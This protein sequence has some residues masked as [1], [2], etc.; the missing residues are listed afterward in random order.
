MR[1][2]Q[3]STGLWLLI[4]D[5]A[6]DID[7]LYKRVDKEL[8]LVDYLPASCKGSIIFTTRNRKAAVKQ[9]GNNII[10]VGEMNPADAKE[11]LKKSLLRTHLLNE[12]EAVIKLLKLLSYLPLAIIQAAAYI[13]ENSIS[14]LSYLALYEGGE[15]EIIE[16][17]S[18]NFEDQG[19]YRDMKNPIA[20]TWLISFDQILQ[21]DQLA[22][23]YLSFMSCLVPENIPKSLLPLTQSPNK[24]LKAIGTLTAYSFITER[25][26]DQ[27]FD[28]HRLVHLATRNWLRREEKLSLWNN[29][30]L[31][32]LADVFP[33]DDH[34]QRAMWTA[35]LPHARH[36]LA[37]PHLLD[38]NR[39]AEIKLLSKVGRCLYSNGQYVEAEQM[40]RRTLEL[41]RKV[42]GPEHPNTLTSMS[43]LASALSSQGKYVEA[44]QMHQQ[45]LELRRKVLGPEHPDTLTSMSEL[46]SALRS[47]GKYVEAEK[48]HQQTLELDREVL[49]PEHPDTLTSMS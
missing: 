22:A 4:I 47:Q 41:R 18:E 35:Y 11:V 45:T 26:L 44:E 2:S 8:P 7:V 6:D 30:A 12:D 1:L 48:M 32:Q 38:G 16:V 31:I 42:L 40:C 10:E 17:L 3:E 23:E 43:E 21:Q 19:R 24:T 34:K 39:K 9:A 15:E 49:G 37:I 28:I 14:I 36:V 27:S 25:E 33:S 46:A 13:N 20:T 29:K 5:N